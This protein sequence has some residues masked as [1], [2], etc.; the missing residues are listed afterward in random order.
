MP[1]MFARSGN[2]G[3]LVSSLPLDHQVVEGVYGFVGCEL[4]LQQFC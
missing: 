1:L 2:G 3:S 4:V